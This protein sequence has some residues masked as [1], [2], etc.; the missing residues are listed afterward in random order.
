M[1]LPVSIADRSI[2]IG[3]GALRV[4]SEEI[5]FSGDSAVIVPRAYPT[6]VMGI[7]CKDTHTPKTIV[8]VVDEYIQDGVDLPWEPQR[9]DRY[10]PWGCLFQINV[11]AGDAP[12]D[13]D[14]LYI[15]RMIAPPKG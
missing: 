15:W 10:E 8:L 6:V 5:K 7:L 3:A 2:V 14:A 9:G 12:L 1:D 11:P 4:A 13:P